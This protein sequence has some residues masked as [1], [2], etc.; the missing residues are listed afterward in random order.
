MCQHGSLRTAAQAVGPAGG[1]SHGAGLDCSNGSAVG[2]SSPARKGNFCPRELLII[3][4]V[5]V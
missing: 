4:Y 2:H 1:V 3:A 5:P